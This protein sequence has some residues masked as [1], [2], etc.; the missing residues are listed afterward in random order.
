MLLIDSS[1]FGISVETTC[2]TS[3]SSSASCFSPHTVHHLLAPL[4][5][6][7][8]PYH[9]LSQYIREVS[10]SGRQAIT[11]CR[12]PEPVR[13]ACPSRGRA[14]SDCT[15]SRCTPPSASSL[16]TSR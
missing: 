12:L 14:R 16:W 13:S 6:L 3:L 7:L 8:G 15:N 10:K 11:P 2:S 9:V 1:S 4:P 5:G